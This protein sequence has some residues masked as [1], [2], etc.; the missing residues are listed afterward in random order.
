MKQ[1]KKLA[2]LLIEGTRGDHS[3]FSKDLEDKG[4]D[5]NFARSGSA[6]LKLLENLTP[7]VLVID[8]ASL[9]T[10]GVRIC[11]SFRKADSELPIV[12]VVDEDVEVPEDV[13][14][15]LVLRLPFT[16]Q[17]LINRIKAY[18]PTDDKFILEAG[19]IELNLQTQ[20]V[21]CKGQL[22]KLTPRL[23]KILKMLM[24]NH[25]KVVER[26]PLFK[27][28]WETNYTGDTRTLDVHISWL[29]QAIEDDPRHPELIRTVR[30][31]GYILDV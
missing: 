30:G 23:V 7:H 2:I 18:E 20:L 6:G 12:L 9:R 1:S 14:A 11:Q 25:G 27:S 31:V 13:D 21:T 10:S 16:V 3:C 28:V 4:Y 19:P 17:K 5:V 15:N 24:K 29:R 22:T 26:D 8:A